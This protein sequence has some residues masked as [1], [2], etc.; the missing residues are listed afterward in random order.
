MPEVE[1]VIILYW[2]TM[3][4][5]V[6]IEL[7]NVALSEQCSTLLRSE[8]TSKSSGQKYNGVVYVIALISN[9]LKSHTVSIKL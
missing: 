9:N 4:P 7:T 5:I 2:H 8:I 3:A 1:D 6:R